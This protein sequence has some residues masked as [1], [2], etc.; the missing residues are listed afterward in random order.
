MTLK[1]PEKAQKGK[2]NL[3]I[4]Q[5]GTQNPGALPKSIQNNGTSPYYDIASYP[6][7]PRREHIPCSCCLFQPDEF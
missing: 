7:P 3:G 2:Q 6:P 4:A 5:K 1:N